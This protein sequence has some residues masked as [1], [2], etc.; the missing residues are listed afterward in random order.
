VQ[1]AGVNANFLMLVPTLAPFP[2]QVVRT[3]NNNAISFPAQTGFSY[4]VQYKNSLTDANWLNVGGV[5][6]GNN[7]IQTVNDT[8]SGDSRFYRAQVSQP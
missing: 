2:L 5:V 4:Q 6:T 7:T 3:G 1:R 8:S